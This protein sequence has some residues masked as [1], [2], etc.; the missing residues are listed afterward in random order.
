MDI[1]LTLAGTSKIRSPTIEAE[2]RWIEDNGPIYYGLPSR[3]KQSG[4]GSWVYFLR[5]GQLKARARIDAIIRGKELGRMSSFS[6]QALP[7]A[8]WNLAVTSMELSKRQIAQRGFQGFRYVTSMEARLFQSA[9][10]GSRQSETRGRVSTAYEGVVRRIV[11]DVP[12]RNPLLRRACREHY[13][14]NCFV[15]GFN[16]FEVYGPIAEGFIHVHH[17]KPFATTKGERLTNAVRDLR[18]V[19]PNCHAVLHLSD[20]ELSISAL[21]RLVRTNKLLRKTRRA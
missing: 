2:A 4:V 16:F 7:T 9:F 6:G 20:P 14:S 3:P 17:V 1:K 19:C 8:A 15:C 12:V 13:G 18:P 5:D 11:A 21:A 10:T